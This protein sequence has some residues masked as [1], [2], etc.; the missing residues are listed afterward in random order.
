MFDLYAAQGQAY[1]LPSAP[2]MVE[3]QFK[4]IFEPTNPEFIGHISAIYRPNQST[5]AS[6][7]LYI[8]H[9]LS[10]ALALASAAAG[11]LR[12]RQLD[13]TPENRQ[14]SFDTGELGRVMRVEDAPGFFLID[15]HAP[16]KLGVAD[17][18]FTHGEIDRSLQRH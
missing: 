3:V 14:G 4:R 7:G 1:R 5:L 15:P 9:Y 16:R 17:A 2:R 12:K 6:Q 8:G 18:S 11:G 10:R 13:V